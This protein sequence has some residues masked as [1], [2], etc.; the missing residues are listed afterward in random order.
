MHLR[1][2][3]GSQRLLVELREDFAD[4]ATIS[5]LDEPLCLQHREGWHAVL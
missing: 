2:R 5:F 4:R 3:C 1:N